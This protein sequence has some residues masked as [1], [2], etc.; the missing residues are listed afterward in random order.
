MR[1]LFL[2]VFLGGLCWGKEPRVLLGTNELAH[3]D[4][5][6]DH[7]NLRRTDLGFK[8]DYVEARFISER[9]LACL[10]KPLSLTEYGDEVMAAVRLIR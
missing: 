6:L 2:V 5:A 10:S 3:L 8:K 9:A 7:M 4:A 1:W